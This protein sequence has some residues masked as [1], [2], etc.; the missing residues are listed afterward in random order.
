[1]VLQDKYSR[2]ASRKYKRTHAP[3]PEQAA[4]HAAV[5]AAI[6][7]VERR[8]LGTNADRYREDDEQKAREEGAATLGPDGQPL[9]ATGEEEVDEEE[10]AHAG[11]CCGLR[12]PRN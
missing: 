8:R 5:D 9:P 1:M 4:E 3:T 10:G 6:R 12:T 2:A 7:E 11:I